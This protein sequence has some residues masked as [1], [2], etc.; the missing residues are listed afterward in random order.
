MPTPKTSNPKKLSELA[1]VKLLEETVLKGTIEEL[2][3]VTET[4]RP[5]EMTARALLLA[6]RYRGAD[7]TKLL[8]E[9][10][11]SF[12]YNITP[13]MLGKYKM[14]HSTAGGNYLTVYAL[15]IAPEK[16]WMN[17]LY[18]P[19]Y[20]VSEMG[21]TS[22]QEE[23]VLRIAERMESVKLCLESGVLN[24]S[25]LGEMLFFALTEN[26]IGFADALIALGANLKDAE[27][28]YYNGRPWGGDYL[29]IITTGQNSAYWSGY[30]TSLIGLE[31]NELLPV[32]E[33]FS[34]L[35]EKEGE[36]LM[37]SQKLADELKWKDDSLRF[38]LEKMNISKINQK[39]LM[40]YAVSKGFVGSLDTMTK[41][42]WLENSAKRE[43]LMEFARLNNFT[44]ALAWLMDFKNRTVDL[45]AEAVKEETKMMKALMENPNSVSA[46]K[47]IWNFTKNEDGTLVITGYKGGETE[48]EIPSV[49]GKSKVT[50]IGEAAFDASMVNLRN[51]YQKSRSKIRK[52]IIPEGVTALGKNVFWSCRSL[53]EI[54]IPSTVKRIE[55]PL[56]NHCPK[57]QKAILPEGVEIIGNTPPFVRCLCMKT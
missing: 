24:Q 44:E 51:K 38:A 53:E 11:A 31:E 28:Y 22:E 12:D 23:N 45:E 19:F 2:R 25:S 54:I 13:S 21:I 41:F 39:K 37:L 34:H 1:K 16:L 6:I 5:F 18:S 35:V 26:A 9:A 14:Q 30:M 8:L 27:P 4:Y 17:Y 43:A 42:G 47:K 29:K 56:A 20:G 10:G 50:A 33:R 55:A 3:A 40:E 7:F 36:K 49:I 46:M 48:V 57:L 15:A 52:V 32:L